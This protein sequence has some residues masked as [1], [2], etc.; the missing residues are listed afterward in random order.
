MPPG[1]VAL[2]VNHHDIGPQG[3]KITIDVRETKGLHHL[4]SP[5]LPQIIGSRV[6]GFHYQW[7]PQCHLG[8]DRS[9]G[10]WHPT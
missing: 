4:G 2:T 3:A 6:T 9:D 5:H 1:M 8:R 7:L 10:S